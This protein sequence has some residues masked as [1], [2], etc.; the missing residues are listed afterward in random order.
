MNESVFHCKNGSRFRSALVSAADG[1]HNICIMFTDNMK[2]D[3]VQLIIESRFKDAIR[4]AFPWSES[5]EGPDLWIEIHRDIK[6]KDP[7]LEILKVQR[8]RTKT[9]WNKRCDT[10]GEKIGGKGTSKYCKGCQYLIRR[11]E[12]KIMTRPEAIE[13][14]REFVKNIKDN[15]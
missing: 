11:Y 2:H 12:S 4:D 15:I 3:V 9:E 7:Y 6:E 13:K 1:D 8:E 5:N 10:C 14:T